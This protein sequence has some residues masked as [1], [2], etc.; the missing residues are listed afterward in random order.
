VSAARRGNAGENKIARILREQGWVVGSMRHSLG[1]GD[2]IAVR[3][4]EELPLQKVA[5]VRLIE[6]KA[7]KR[8]PFQ[9]F[10]P[11]ERKSMLEYAALAGATAWVAWLPP[12]AAIRWI[13]SEDWPTKPGPRPK[14]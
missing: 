6:V 12:R 5:E 4:F 14:S 3:Q 1:A 7:T 11:A 9:A 13:P 10:L 2:L 8:T